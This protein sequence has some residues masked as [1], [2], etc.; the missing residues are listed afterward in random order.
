[1]F[2]VLVVAVGLQDS[3][4]AGEGGERKRAGGRSERERDGSEKK[5]SSSYINPH[6]YA[7]SPLVKL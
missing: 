1:M 5:L 3:R 7:P 4:S 6:W 2:R